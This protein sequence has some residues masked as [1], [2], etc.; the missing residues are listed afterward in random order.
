MSETKKSPGR[1]KNR[2]EFLAVQAGE[3][4]R[5]STFLLEVLDRKSPE[6][7]PRVGF[8]VTKRQGNA[9]ERNRMRRRLKEAVRLSAG[10][11]MKPGHDYVIVARRDVLDTAFPKLQSLLAERIE[12]TAKPKRSQETR[13]RKE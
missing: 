3:K 8:T 6:T 4:R 11:A 9:V 1:L 12:G 10:V 13:S 7:E 2:S 5:G